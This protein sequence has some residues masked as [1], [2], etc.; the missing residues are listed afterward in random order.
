MLGLID[1]RIRRCMNHGV[2]PDLRQDSP[3]PSGIGQVEGGQVERDRVSA[4]L[5]TQ[6]MSQLSFGAGHGNSWHAATPGATAFD[7]LGHSCGNGH[8]SGERARMAR[9]AVSLSE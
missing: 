1:L 4:K 7:R 6:L 2:G 3:D 5:T 8:D 9:A